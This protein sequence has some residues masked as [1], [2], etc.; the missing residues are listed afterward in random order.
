[1]PPRQWAMRITDI[2][3][4]IEAIQEF[5]AGTDFAAFARDRKTIDAV[6][7]NLTSSGRPPATCRRM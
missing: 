2:L 4:A 6:L 1:M 7:R 5:T 3:D